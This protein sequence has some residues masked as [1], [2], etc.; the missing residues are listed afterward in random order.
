MRGVSGW[1]KTALLGEWV[2]EWVPNLCDRKPLWEHDVDVIPYVW[3][4]KSIPELLRGLNLFLTQIWRS[5]VIKGVFNAKSLISSV[6][7]R[8]SDV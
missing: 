1:E 3:T 8:E 5:P 6:M 2:H 7:T 4:H